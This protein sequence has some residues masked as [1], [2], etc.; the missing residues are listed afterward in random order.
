MSEFMEPHKKAKPEPPD[1]QCPG[2]GNLHT[3]NHVSMWK[4][5]CKPC[6]WGF[7]HPQSPRDYDKEKEA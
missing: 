6:R 1:N 2:C 3:F 5:Y 7:G 4:Y